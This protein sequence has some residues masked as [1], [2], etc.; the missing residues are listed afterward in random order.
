MATLQLLDPRGAWREAHH[1][2]THPPRDPWDAQHPL[3]DLCK[4]RD[5]GPILYLYNT[6]FLSI[7]RFASALFI[8]RRGQPLPHRYS[9]K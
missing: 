6:N 5:G 9:A 3:A 7:R 8:H 2:Q 4:R 1:N